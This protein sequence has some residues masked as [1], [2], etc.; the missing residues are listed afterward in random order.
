MRPGRL[1]LIFLA[2]IPAAL[3][4]TTLLYWAGMRWLEGDPRSLLHSFQWAAET[5]TTTGY[6]SD[7]RWDHPLM[8]A[9]V[10]LVQFGGVFLVVLV[11]PVVLIPFLESRF[12]V[13]LPRSVPP[14]LTGH[15][16]IYGYG[17]AVVTLIDEVE[18]AGV[19]TVIAEPNESVARRLFESGR[20][21]VHAGLDEDALSEVGLERARALV[22][23][24]GDEENAAVCL[25][26]R[27]AG[28]GGEIYAVAE[29]P[30]HRHPLALAGATAVYTP[31]HVLG[32]AL[33][34]RASAR[35]SPRIAGLHELGELEVRELRVQPQSEIVGQPPAGAEVVVVG[36]WRGGTL[37]AP[38][39]RN[40]PAAVG[41]ILIA[42]G[43]DGP[44][45]T[46]GQRCGR[47]G[48]ARRTGPFLVGGYGEVGKKVVELLRDAG[49]AVVVVDR[50]PLPGV[51][52]VGDIFDAALIERLGVDHAQA[53]IL[54]LDSD[55]AALFATVITKATAPDVP[56]IARVNRPENVER[57]HRAG[58]DFALSISQVAGQLLA[59][60]LLGAE[61]VDV[62]AQ[63]RLTKEPAERHDWIGQGI[64]AAARL[65]A[66]V[67]AVERGGQLLVSPHGDFRFAADDQVYLCTARGSF[68]GA[69]PEPGAG[70]SRSDRRSPRGG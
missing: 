12:E 38:I 61:A 56:V 14:R 17:P 21:V 47:R 22:A 7:S 54:A 4:V 70:P 69:R 67:V 31:R 57:L 20:R 63:L 15:L 2:A 13:R 33:A 50:Q 3:A 32:A 8:A 45:D 60:R 37:E 43:T 58:A 6:G 26:A 27:Q 42:I 52:V 10:A 55:S 24:A 19:P 66:T 25:S 39:D 23:N 11:L 9:F 30:R 41:E 62:D 53:V 48:P 1:A 65:R 40:L 44:L 5:I 16:V 51:E 59:R 28:F 35:I 29:E 68:S 46:F 64:S 36:R 18:R 49:E 34:A